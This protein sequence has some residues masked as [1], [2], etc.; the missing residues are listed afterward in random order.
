[1]IRSL[2]VILVVGVLFAG[3]A[4]AYVALQDGEEEDQDSRKISETIETWYQ[5]TQDTK[6]IGFL[7]IILRPV[8]EMD[9]AYEISSDENMVIRSG[10][11]DSEEATWLSFSVKTS[12]KLSKEFDLVEIISRFSVRGVPVEVKLETESGRRRIEISFPSQD[13]EPLVFGGGSAEVAVD[14]H[15]AIFKLWH[16]GAL[17]KEGTLI[18]RMLR[19]ELGRAVAVAVRLDVTGK[20]QKKYFGQES[21]VTQIEV[22]DYPAIEAMQVRT[23]WV[24]GSAASWRWRSERVSA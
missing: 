8:N 18:L 14:L 19:Y 1:M 6:H 23:L 11:A 9:W 10:E 15:T 24:D 12:G 13:E 7:H 17:D 20:I 21:E 5:I 22:S 4:V 16:S 3:A 2:A